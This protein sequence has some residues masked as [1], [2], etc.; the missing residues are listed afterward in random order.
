[1]MS[2]TLET[3]KFE[4]NMHDYEATL[5]NQCKTILK[6]SSV[7]YGET[8]ARYVPPLVN[9]KWSK[10]IP[11]KMYKRD[12]VAPLSRLVKSD[13]T[14]RKLFSAK[15]REGYRFAVKGLLRG[16]VHWWFA[17]TL[18]KTVQY[19]K[20]F[21]R[22]LFKFL[23]GANFQSIGEQTP[24]Y[25]TKLLQKSPNLVKHIKEHILELKTEEKQESIRIVNDAFNNDAF[26]RESKYRGEKAAK[27]E[28]KRLFTE[29]EKKKYEV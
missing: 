6:K 10:T 11:A 26:S 19:T 28:M 21:N 2:Y 8:A 27:K 3:K 12:F 5:H 29:W 4:Q 1:M 24:T 13:T 20:I 25:F 23:F 17:T 18:R 7:S 22:G 9:G 14:N 15:L 16:K